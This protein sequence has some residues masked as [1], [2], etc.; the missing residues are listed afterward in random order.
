VKVMEELDRI[1]KLPRAHTD[2]RPSALHR[3]VGPGSR[4]S[5]TAKC[6]SFT[7]KWRKPCMY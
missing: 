5:H 2:L 4:V 3:A 6:R 1:P 7:R